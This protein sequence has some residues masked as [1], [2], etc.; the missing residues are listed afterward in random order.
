MS[1]TVALGNVGASDILGV[2]GQAQNGGHGPLSQVILDCLSRVIHQESS[3]RV[4]LTSVSQ[5]QLSPVLRWFG[6]FRCS[7]SEVVAFPK[8]EEYDGKVQGAVRRLSQLRRL[9]YY[10]DLALRPSDNG[11]SSLSDLSSHRRSRRFRNARNVRA[12]HTRIVSATLAS[13]M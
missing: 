6:S 13:I 7:L 8:Q 9:G 2:L 12:D 3:S 11:I 10:I 4:I 5:F 1:G